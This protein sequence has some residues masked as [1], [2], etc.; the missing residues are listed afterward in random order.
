MDLNFDLDLYNPIYSGPKHEL[1]FF[2]NIPCV[3]MHCEFEKKNCSQKDKRL[4]VV[5]RWMYPKIQNAVQKGGPLAIHFAHLSKDLQYTINHA[6]VVPKEFNLMPALRTRGQ[7]GTEIP[8]KPA[9]FTA[10]WK[11][12]L[13]KLMKLNTRHASVLA[14]LNLSDIP[15]LQP[16]TFGPSPNSSAVTRSPAFSMSPLQLCGL[17]G[18]ND[19]SAA[20]DN[21]E[22]CD[23]LALDEPIQSTSAGAVATY[24]MNTQSTTASSFSSQSLQNQ[25]SMVNQ[26]NNEVEGT[27][28]LTNSDESLEE[29]LSGLFDSNI[30]DSEFSHQEQNSTSVLATTTNNVTCPA[31]TALIKC[32]SKS[33]ELATTDCSETEVK[34]KKPNMVNI[35]IL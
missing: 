18:F 30:Y 2:E 4:I 35:S 10:F 26:G 1:L 14:T 32:S 5:P 17:Y 34:K 21:L 15:Q 8:S 6:Q 9:A 13:T 12:T 16:S 33:D 7:T 24:K 25:R 19:S 27:I 22:E 28:P 11:R 23:P 29:S 3:R 31:L 20:N